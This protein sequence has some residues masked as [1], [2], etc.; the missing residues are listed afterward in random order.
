MLNLAK[1]L[2]LAATAVALAAC[3]D[4][5]ADLER[6]KQGATAL[7]KEALNVGA[8]VLDTRNACLLAGQSES[9][10]G[11]LSER[12]GSDITP[13]HVQALTEMVR[14][15]VEGEAA[16]TAAESVSGIDAQSREAVVQC[17]ARSAVEGAISEG[18]N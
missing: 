3:G 4:L 11:C 12:L 15:S 1:P 5:N 6:A 10:C 9:F 16:E 8:D 14:K 2:I 7:G 13:E 17:A 18:A